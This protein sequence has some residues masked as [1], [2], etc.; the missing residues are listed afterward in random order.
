MK[1]SFSVSKNQGLFGAEHE[2]NRQKIQK[3][4]KNYRQERNRKTTLINEPLSGK[5][6]PENGTSTP[7]Q[8]RKISF[9]NW[10]GVPVPRRGGMEGGVEIGSDT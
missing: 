6:K 7:Y 9:R 8:F 10:Y 1:I 5:E 2:K 3:N 4:P